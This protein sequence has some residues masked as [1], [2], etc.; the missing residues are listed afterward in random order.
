MKRYIL[1]LAALLF[2]AAPAWAV[3]YTVDQSQ[4]SVTFSGTQADTAFTGT[5]GK[6]AAAIDFEADNPAASKINANFDLA[7]AVTGNKMFDGT[8][9]QSDWFDV[10]NHP[11]AS[12][13]STAMHKNADGSFQVDGDLT[14]RGITK[15]VSFPFTLDNEAGDVVNATATLKVDR[16]AYDI[17]RKSDDKAEWVSRDITVTIKLHAVKGEKDLPGNPDNPAKPVSGGR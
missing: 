4:S 9:P 14:L 10:K 7:S 17:G 11:Q 13:T 1:P 8:L 6:W 3:P 15:P 2:T 16:L 5:F 12:F